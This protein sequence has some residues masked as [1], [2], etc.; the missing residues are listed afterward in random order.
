MNQKERDR[1]RKEEARPAY[2][3][4][5]KFYPFSV[6]SLDGEEWKVFAGSNREF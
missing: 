1:R 5:M 3:A 2:N 4:L 6:E